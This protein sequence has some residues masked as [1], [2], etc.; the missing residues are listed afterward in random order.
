MEFEQ[1]AVG[2][3]NADE[4]MTVTTTVEPFTLY[5]TVALYAAIA[6]SVP[7]LLWQ[8]WGFISPALL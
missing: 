5:A 3:P 8:I 6:I 7:F 1:T 4:R 2:T